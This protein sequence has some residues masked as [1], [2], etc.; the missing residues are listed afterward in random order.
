[1]HDCE[2]PRNQLVMS[3]VLVVGCK[4]GVKADRKATMAVAWVASQQGDSMDNCRFDNLTRVIAA[5]ADRRTAVKRFAGGLAALAALARVE[6]GFAQD[7]EGE[8][9]CLDNGSRCRRSG[10][11]C[12]LKCR[13]RRGRKRGRCKCAGS[14]ADCKADIGC[15]TGVCRSGTCRCGNTTDF[16]TNDNDCCSNNCSS[17]KCLCITKNQRC[18]SSANCC[19][20]LTCKSGFCNS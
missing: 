9:K 20:G 3:R 1:M 17:G 14:G 4:L 5:Q 2:A 10:Q 6:L 13:R 12:S 16:C 18:N 8:I 7:V 11:C 15:C 19:S